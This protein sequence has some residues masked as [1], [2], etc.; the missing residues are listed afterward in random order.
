MSRE[1]SLGQHDQRAVEQAA[2]FE[3]QHELRDRLIDHLLQLDHPLVPVVV[4]VPVFERDVLARHFDESRAALDQPPRQQ[5][6][7]PEPPDVVLLVRLLRLERQVERLRRGRREQPVRVVHRAQQRLLLEVAPESPT[8]D[9]ASIFLYSALRFSNRDMS[10]PFGGEIDFIASAGSGMMN[11]PYSLPRN[12]AVRK[13]LSSSVSASPTSG[14]CPMSMNA[15]I[16]RLARPERA[17]HDAAD[18]RAVHGLRRGV[19][20]VPVELVPRVQD[21]P[22]VARLVR[23]DQRRAVHHLR[24]SFQNPG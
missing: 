12:P 20:G 21:E 19:A 13:A 18:V 16:A 9:A 6:P 5:T 10:M 11:G 24:E 17:R 3:V 22:E 1:N 2:L 7:E 23:A 14:R 8:G 4:R 15:G